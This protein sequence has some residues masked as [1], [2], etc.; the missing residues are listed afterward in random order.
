MTYESDIKKTNI[1]G[2]LL[3]IKLKYEIAYGGFD[4]AL[5]LGVRYSLL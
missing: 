2:N 5:F 3:C 1:G 4:F